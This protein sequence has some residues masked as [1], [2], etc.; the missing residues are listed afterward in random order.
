MNNVIKWGVLGCGNIAHKFVSDLQY[1]DNSTLYAVASNNKERGKSF[2]NKHN[3]KKVYN[4][5]NNLVKDENVD[6]VYVATTHNFHYQNTLLCLDANKPVLCEKPLC[7]NAKE[8]QLLIDI[9]KQKK[10]FLMEAMWTRFLPAT[11]HLIKE[12]SDGVI[13]K[14]KLIQAD[15]GIKKP[16]I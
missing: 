6:I 12:I 11:K 14:P 4:N 3:A 8:A 2:A 7:V 9:A 1:V 16:P 13:G 10:T 15:F 5:Y